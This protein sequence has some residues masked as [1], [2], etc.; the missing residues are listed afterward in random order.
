M[1]KQLVQEI[2]AA[3]PGVRRMPGGGGTD[4]GGPEGEK[5]PGECVCDGEAETGYFGSGIAFWHC[6]MPVR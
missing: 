3:L 1:M 2:F 4:G 5:C 6:W